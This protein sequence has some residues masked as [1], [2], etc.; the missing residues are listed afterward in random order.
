MHVVYSPLCF[1][2][3]PHFFEMQVLEPLFNFASSG[4]GGDAEH[5][6]STRQVLILFSS[7]TLPLQP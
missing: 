1:S 2:I 5:L 6:H 3:E 4:R 7:V